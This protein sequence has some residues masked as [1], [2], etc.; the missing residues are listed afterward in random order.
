[1]SKRFCDSDIWSKDWFLDLS[2]KKKLLLKFLF[3]NCDC[4]GIYEISYRTLKN[5][6]NEEVTKKDFEGLKQIKFLNENT[7]F[8]EDFIIFQCGIDSIKDLNPSNNAHKGIIKKLKKYNLYGAGANEPLVS[9]SL[10][11]K[12]PLTSPSLGALCGALC[13]AQE[14]EKEKEKDISSS[15]VL[16][17]S[18]PDNEKQKLYGKYGNVCLTAEQYNRLLGIC[19]SQ[20]LLDEL[21]DS[22]SENIEE[23]REKPYSAEFP[24]AHF[25]RL[26]KYR[27]F[28]LK[29]PDKF[30][31]HLKIVH[32]AATFEE[33]AKARYQQEIDDWLTKTNKEKT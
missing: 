7:I 16:S 33:R 27:A 21:V 6:F 9:P 26:E 30:S 1:M 14:K 15:L 17:S 12:E 10:A 23:G 19:A 24:N 25:V 32:G 18:L 8:I 3:D 20:K 4:A 28:R 22:L 11:P 5:C 13:G 2:I 31:P 29:N